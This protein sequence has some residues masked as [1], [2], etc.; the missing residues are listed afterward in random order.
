MAMVHITLF[1]S[2]HLISSDLNSFT[3]LIY[4]TL[5]AS[6][7]AAKR[8]SLPWL[9]PAR[10]GETARELL[11]SDWSQPR[12]TRSLYSELPAT[13][14]S[15]QEAFEKM[16]GQIRH[17]MHT[18]IH[19]VSLLSHARIDFHDDNDANNNNDNYA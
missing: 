7:C 1:I 5:T 10:Q 8:P 11:R 3:D 4:S 12:R 6:E 18:P 16:L 13:R 19:Q 2:F 17:C 9:R 14:F 15:K